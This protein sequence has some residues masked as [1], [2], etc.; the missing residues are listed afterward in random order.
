VIKDQARP[1]DLVGRRFRVP[2][3]NRLRVAADIT[4]LSVWSGRFAYLAFVIAVFPRG[5]GSQVLQHG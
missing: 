2:A 4:Y 3:P 1:A 5:S